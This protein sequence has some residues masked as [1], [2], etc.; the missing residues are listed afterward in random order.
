MAQILFRLKDNFHPDPEKDRRGSYKKGYPVSIKEDGWYEGNPYWGQSAYAD[1][2]EWI[3]VDVADA[4]VAELEGFCTAWKDDF[5]YEI[6]SSNA[7]T[8]QYTVRVYETNVSAK[9]VNALTQEKVESFLTK[10][11]CSNLS[12]ATN[13]VQFDISLWDAVRSEGFWGVNFVTFPITFTLISYS[14]VTG[15]GRIEATV[16]ASADASLVSQKI[17]DRGGSIVSESHPVWTFD[18]E[19]SDLLTKFRADVKEKA[20]KTYRRR[21]FS[22]TP[23]QSDAIATAG[24]YITRTKAQVIAVLKSGLED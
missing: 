10:W 5:S 14:A 7:S 9:G 2:T 16:P 3:V 1:K 24:G 22:L 19:R 15:I 20:Q 12:F 11:R 6:L 21:L 4:T 8:G 17:Q 18:I 23:A 13:S